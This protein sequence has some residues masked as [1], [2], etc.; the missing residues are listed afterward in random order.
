MPPKTGWFSE[1]FDNHPWYN[2]KPKAPEAYGTGMRHRKVYCS[3][4]HRT[5]LQDLQ[6]KENAMHQ[7][8]P[9]FSLKTIDE[10]RLQCMH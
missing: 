2:N 5:N 10:L 6:Q 9:T 7:Q 8:D 1:F 4:C 3:A